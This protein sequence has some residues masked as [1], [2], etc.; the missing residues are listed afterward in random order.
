MVIKSSSR[1]KD[2]RTIAL[3]GCLRPCGQ[4][5]VPNPWFPRKISKQQG[6][7][8]YKRHYSALGQATTI[9]LLQKFFLLKRLDG[10]QI[11]QQIYLK[12]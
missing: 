1:C 6:S 7:I 2:R 8:G 11:S 3:D 4:F 12:F 9:K 5:K 10:Q